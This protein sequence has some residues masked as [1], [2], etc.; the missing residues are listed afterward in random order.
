MTAYQTSKTGPFCSSG[1]SSFAFMPVPDFLDGAGLTELQKLL[2]KHLQEENVPRAGDPARQ[3]RN[4]LLRSI[5][6]D[7]HEGS[8]AFFTY[9]A[10]SNTGNSLEL[11]PLGVDL[12][13][14]NYITLCAAL[15]HPFSSGNVHIASSNPTRLSIINPKYLSHPLDV[16]ILARHVRYLE[17]IAA[18]EPLASF[19]KPNGRRNAPGAYAI[20]E[21]EAAKDYIRSASVSNWHC[22]G[23]CAMLPRDKGG[24][25]NERLI[26]HGT[27]NLRVV[28]ASIMPMIPQA[29]TQSTVYAVA[30]RAADLIKA[31]HTLTATP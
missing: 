28:D 18:T 9:T 21:P 7:P 29:N 4:E 14:G 2:E 25:V 12:Q 3:Q 10:Q 23:T 6:E 20:G 27:K 19:L 11:K 24:V 26:V 1:V 5:L 8:A 15:L 30:E 22:V 16:E 31:D 17:I 13:P